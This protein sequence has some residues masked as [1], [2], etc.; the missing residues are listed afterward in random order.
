MYANKVTVAISQQ[1]C[2]IKFSCL[3]PKFDEEGNITSAGDLES[4]QIVMNREMIIK[5]RDMITEVFEK[6]V[7][8]KVN[9]NE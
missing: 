6:E 8:E 7:I 5:L 4:C 3:G 1:E 9:S 2:H